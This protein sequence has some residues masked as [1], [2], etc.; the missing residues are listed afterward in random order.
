MMNI[1]VDAVVSQHGLQYME[2]NAKYAKPGDIGA[3]KERLVKTRATDE[4]RAAVDRVISAIVQLNE[5]KDPK[6]K[7]AALK[8]LGH[9]AGEIA[10]GLR[11]LERLRSQKGLSEGEDHLIHAAKFLTDAVHAVA[12]RKDQVEA[13]KILGVGHDAGELERLRKD[14]G[15]INVSG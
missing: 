13:A 3:L 5:T 11:A 12:S 6:N 1:D 15:K 7:V 8:R 4:E 10:L 9:R 14:L 2:N